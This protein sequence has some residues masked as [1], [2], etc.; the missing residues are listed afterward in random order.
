M[1]VVG[2]ERPSTALATAWLMEFILSVVEGLRMPFDCTRRLS[3]SGCSPLNTYI[4]SGGASFDMA[5]HRSFDAAEGIELAERL[6]TSWIAEF[7]SSVSSPRLYS[8][9]A[10]QA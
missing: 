4:L 6:A 5:Q 10:G 8:G 3:G 1:Q 2:G 7:I 9:Q